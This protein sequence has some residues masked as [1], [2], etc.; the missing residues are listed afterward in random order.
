MLVVLADICLAVLSVW[1]V[2][3]LIGDFILRPNGLMSISANAGD[4][5]N[6]H[7][8]AVLFWFVQL[9]FRYVG[10]LTMP[11]II[12]AIVVYS[13]ISIALIALISTSVRE[14]RLKMKNRVT[15]IQPAVSATYTACLAIAERLSLRSL[16]SN[17]WWYG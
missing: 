1:L 5:L 11:S 2:Y 15:R 14:A 13:T 17:G 7:T 16:S 9:V 4:Q 10:V 12:K 6:G 3:Y 8:A